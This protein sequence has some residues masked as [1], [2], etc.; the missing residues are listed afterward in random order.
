MEQFGMHETK[1]NVGQADRL[2]S[3]GTGALL[4]MIGLRRGW[5]HMAFTALGGYLLYRGLTGNCKI[6]EAFDLDSTGRATAVGNELASGTLPR[7]IAVEHWLTVNRP[8]SEVYGFWRHLENL[9]RFMRYLQTVTETDAMR[10]HWVAKTPIGGI[11]VEWDAEITEEIPD[12]RL[13]WGS[14]PGSTLMTSGS[15]DFTP[16]PG[17]RGTELHVRM[18]YSPPGGAAGAAVARVFNQITTQSIEDDLHRF[19]EVM[20]TGV[21]PST[22]GRFGSR[23]NR[24]GSES[25]PRRTSRVDRVQEASEESFP[26]SDPPGYTGGSGT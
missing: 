1:T 22:E 11:P 10:S 5:V 24:P 20:E 15:V 2:F 3:I 4:T 8:V 19:K 25:E 26:A 14:Q 17:D 7:E 9:P 18:K 13:A 23:G 16:A 12:R 6:Y 21:M